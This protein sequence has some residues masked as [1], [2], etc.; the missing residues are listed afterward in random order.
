M[1]CHRTEPTTPQAEAGHTTED[2]DE[3]EDDYTSHRTYVVDLEEQSCTCN[4]HMYNGKTCVHMVAAGYR[5]SMGD[6]AL[7]KSEFVREALSILRLTFARHLL[8]AAESRGIRLFSSSR[9]PKL[10][11]LEKLQRLVTQELVRDPYSCGIQHPPGAGGQ[12]NGGQEDGGDEDPDG[13]DGDGGANAEDVYDDSGS[14]SDFNA[15]S[16]SDADSAS[17]SEDDRGDYPDTTPLTK[18]R[19]RK[20]TSQRKI[21]SS[22]ML[23]SMLAPL[24]PNRGKPGRPPAEKFFPIKKKT[25]REEKKKKDA[26]EKAKAKAEKK[27]RTKGAKKGSGANAA[28][29]KQ[30]APKIE[31]PL[32]DVDGDV[33]DEDD[34]ADDDTPVPVKRKP[35]ASSR[36]KDAVARPLSKKVP[37][38]KITNGS[39][40][41]PIA[42]PATEDSIAHANKSIVAEKRIRELSGV[43]GAD[44]GSIEEEEINNQRPPKR[45]RLR[46]RGDA[47]VEQDN[48]TSNQI[49][50]QGISMDPDPPSSD[51]RR[52]LKRKKLLVE[53]DDETD[54]EEQ[55]SDVRP[56][57]YPKLDTSPNAPEP[58]AIPNSEH[59]EHTVPSSLYFPSLAVSDPPGTIA[60]STSAPS[61][62]AQLQKFRPLPLPSEPPAHS[63]T[64][65]SLTPSTPTPP[66][67]TSPRPSATATPFVQDPPNDLSA[68]A[69][70]P[71][72]STPPPAAP[73]NVATTPVVQKRHEVFDH[74]TLEE[75]RIWSDSGD[76]FNPHDV[77]NGINTIDCRRWWRLDNKGRHYELTWQEISIFVDSLNQVS[78][79][80]SSDVYFLHIPYTSAFREV[81]TGL[82]WSVPRGHESEIFNLV[83]TFYSSCGLDVDR[84]L[85]S[86]ENRAAED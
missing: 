1:H 22:R 18:V 70:Q 48:D 6:P 12:D 65:Q 40:K 49:D 35:G 33:D 30:K 83:R 50:Q 53:S 75:E 11:K 63:A 9:E 13:V 84:K 45:R 2:E 62:L 7:T 19:N 31:D 41:P 59:S 8:L 16:D 34:W 73:V 39:K 47:S 60:V 56:A 38:K 3:D 10:E 20:G 17:D 81:I 57:K 46:K 64:R 32:D 80:C 77:V 23:S 29:K 52:Y 86:L 4:A 78:E 61:D 55:P 37:P 54:E 74:L 28:A 82:D 71:R 36:P 21:K 79:R 67:T 69:G 5:E 43:G 25:L 58:N 42:K 76:L 15:D 26:E 24:H 66:L 27:A 44:E 68:N 14:D 72:S 51:A 85:F